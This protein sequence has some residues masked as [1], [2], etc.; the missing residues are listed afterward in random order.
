MQV[1]EMVPNSWYD[2]TFQI[3]GLH[4]KPQIMRA[5]FLGT[6]RRNKDWTDVSFSLRPKAGTTSLR[7]DHISG[8]GPA[9]NEKPMLPRKK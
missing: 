1:S 5:Q 4:K 9:I 7:A 6:I 8:I 2:I 3:P